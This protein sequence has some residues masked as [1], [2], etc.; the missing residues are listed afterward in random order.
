[1]ETKSIMNHQ[2]EHNSASS[3]P[4]YKYL[5][6]ITGLFVAVLLISN[7]AATKIFIIGPLPFDGGALLF[8]LSYIFCDVLTEVYGYRASRRVIWTGF[9]SCILMIIVFNLVALLPP[10]AEWKPNQAAFEAILLAAQRI[11]LA[12][13]VAYLAGEFLNAY[14]LAKMKI[15][16]QGRW[17]W[18]R[19]IGSTLVGQ[20]A[21][22]TIFVLIAFAGTLKWGTIWNIIW[23][24]YVFKCSVE[25]LFTPIT[26]TVVGWL[27]R[28]EGVD[29]YDIDTNFSPF[30]IFESNY[31]SNS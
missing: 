5:D 28:T 11:V 16:T 9:A 1:M 20:S 8:P 12:S 19:T 26:Y 25:V 24:G 10:E 17:L 14:V 31:S 2:L 30:K 29:H 15:K 23:V 6:I 27:K 3:R 18:T 21:D 7:V 22:T 13:I 4:G